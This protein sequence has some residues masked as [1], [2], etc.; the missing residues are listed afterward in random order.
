MGTKNVRIDESLERELKYIQDVI[1]KQIN[2]I[3]L[4]QPQASKIAARILSKKRGK[5]NKIIIKKSK[6]KRVS[7]LYL[8][9]TKWHFVDLIL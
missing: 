5:I 8:I 1:K 3:D 7:E 4:S 9:W 2:G 6:G